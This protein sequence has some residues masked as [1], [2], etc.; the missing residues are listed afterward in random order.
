MATKQ[1]SVAARPQNANGEKMSIP[2][3]E[4]TL[5]NRSDTAAALTEVGFPIKAATLATRATRGG[6]PPYQKFGRTALY[7]WADAVAWARS[8]LSAPVRNTSE[9][10]VK[11]AA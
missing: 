11:A 4:D 10:S 2:Q 3:N 9:S 5:L 7:K 1:R 8:R 6:G